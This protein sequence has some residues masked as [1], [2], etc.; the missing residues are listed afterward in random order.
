MNLHFAFRLFAFIALLTLLACAP[1]ETP[2]PAIPTPAEPSPT[3]PQ[4]VAT[5][6]PTPS[7]T[8]L[9]TLPL[10]LEVPRPYPQWARRA[11]IAGAY[12]EPGEEGTYEARLDALAA[13]HVSV[14]LA[15]CP[16]GSFY[17]A[18]ADDA[19]FAANRDLIRRVTEGAHRRGMK[20]VLYLTSL[21]QI[22]EEGATAGRNPASAHPD[23]VQVSLEGDPLA[24]SDI[25]SEQEHWLE[26]GEIDVWMA[27]RSGYRDF[28]LSRVREVMTSGVDGLWIDVTYLPESIGGHEGLWPSHDPFSAEAF[29]AAYGLELPPAEDWDDEAWRKWIVWR[30]EDLRHF[31]LAVKDEMKAVN[32]KAVFFE[33]NWSADGSGATTYGND[34]TIYA[35]LSDVATGHEIGTIGDRMDRGETGMEQA[36]LEQWQAF[37]TMVKFARGAD[38]GKPSWILTY[39]YQPDD[40]IR[41]AGVIASQGANYYETR[42][43]GMADSV[44]QDYRRQIFGWMAAHEAEI[45]DLESLAQVALLYSGRNRDLVD[46]G[47]GEPYKVEDDGFLK[48]YRAVASTL[49]SAHVPFDIVVDTG[50]TLD[51][52]RP[53]RWLVLAGVECLSDSQAAL[54]RDFV[55]NG[56]RIVLTGDAGWA[57]E[58][59]RPRQTNAL[60]GVPAVIIETVADK[61]GRRQLLGALDGL[62]SLDTNAPPEVMVEVRGGRRLMTL[63]LVN[64]G[65]EPVSDLNF[66]LRWPEGQTVYEVRWTDP[67]GSDGPLE[68]DLQD[69]LLSLSV[70]KLYAVGLVTIRF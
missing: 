57:D 23:W 14:V 28:Y 43:P 32:P 12:F 20:V 59:G 41:L 56:G 2:A 62:P 30:H 5:P 9:D 17:S 40:A 48:E 68:Y 53:Y 36:S 47:G 21:E 37:A 19:E 22:A 34:P 60:D 39:G 55:D 54:V 29:Q 25:S 18:W 45:F 35:P 70:P 69:G 65:R 58:W 4:P 3:A 10:R 63:T 42:G 8:F 51:H 61:A 31:L 66:E 44:G 13:Q 7:P 27:P 64:F 50:L 49:F 6:V 52:L 1:E 26:E 46:Q 24:F 11:R 15:D 67:E 33:E 38:R 16:L